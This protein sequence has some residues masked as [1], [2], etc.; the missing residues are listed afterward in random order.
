MNPT[1]QLWYGLLLVAALVNIALYVY[2]TQTPAA[3]SYQS[4]LRLLA[5]PV[6]LQCAWRSVFPSLYLQ[7]YVFWDTPLNSILLDRSFACVGELTWNTMLA[8]CFCHIDKQLA[9]KPNPAGGGTAWV[10]TSAIA[11]V[12]MYV[13]AECTS[14]YNTATENELF[15]AIEVLL[16]ATSQAFLLPATVFLFTKLP[17]AGRWSLSATYFLIA[18]ALQALFLIVYNFAI[19]AP[20]YYARYEADQA[21]GKH[22]LPFG[23][24]L[25]DAATHRVPTH[26]L[27]DWQ[28]DMLWMVGYFVFNPLAATIVAWVAPSS[29]APASSEDV[30]LELKGGGGADHEGPAVGVRTHALSKGWSNTQ[31]GLLLG[32]MLLCKVVSFIRPHT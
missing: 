28:A 31:C 26:L 27:K 24:G 10:R 5:F 3:Q 4:Q 15:A 11:M 32:A 21:A 9:P 12:I 13:V 16:D 22:Y 6:V 8:L 30:E 2:S 20:M 1:V 29:A 17:A 18:F 19:D 14:Y 7:R 23:E 25:L